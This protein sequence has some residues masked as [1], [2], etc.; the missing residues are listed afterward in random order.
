MNK[1]RMTDLM[2]KANEILESSGIL[3]KMIIINGILKSRTMGKHPVL[4]SL[5]P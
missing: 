2:L 4:E 3:Q 1:K 5:L